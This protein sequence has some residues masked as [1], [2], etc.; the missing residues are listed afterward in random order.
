MQN[1]ERNWNGAPKIIDNKI[2][3]GTMVENTLVGFGTIIID[4]DFINEMILIA[5][6]VKN[7]KN[8]LSL[9]TKINN[10]IIDYFYSSEANEYS[11][12]ET[13]INNRV[14]EDGLI[15]GTKL[16]SLKG[17]N[18]ALCSEKTI[19]AYIILEYLFSQGNITRKPLFIL[20]NLAS[21]NTKPGPHAFIILNKEK[22]NDPTKHL[23]FDPE[24]PAL[25]KNKNGVNQN[26]AGLYS[27]TD[28]EYDNLINNMSCTPKSL[29]SFF[30]EKV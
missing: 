1:I 30:D 25:I 4:N 27:L 5:N 17:K 7:D 8:L 9:I 3:S 29:Y 28:E 22:C 23:I 16:S 11:R 15:I 10:K 24:N 14:I 26:Y 2:E 13:Y 12:S 21:P 18:I 6:D 19:A 20:S